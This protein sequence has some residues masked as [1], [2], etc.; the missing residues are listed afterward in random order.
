MTA[1]IALATMMLL[2]LAATPSAHADEMGGDPVTVSA[3]ESAAPAR[4]ARGG[5]PVPEPDGGRFDG[6]IDHWND[7]RPWRYGTQYLYGLTR[8]MDDAG[9]PRPAQYV[10][11]VFTA[12]ADTANL[13][14]A[15]IAGLF[16]S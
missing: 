13:P 2:A 5:Q 12:I 11:G 14:I 10:L 7:Q 15:A 6:A 4:G 9:V 16:G 3:P 8:G 1:R